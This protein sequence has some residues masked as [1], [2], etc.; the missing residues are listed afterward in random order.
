MV[1]KVKHSTDET[2]RPEYA[3]MRNPI[4]DNGVRV[5]RKEVVVEGPSTWE[6]ATHF[7]A[8]HYGIHVLGRGVMVKVLSVWER[9]SNFGAGPAV[10]SLLNRLYRY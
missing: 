10:L 4:R 5:L 6:R 8:G 1:V 2:E 7:G 9:A 3:V